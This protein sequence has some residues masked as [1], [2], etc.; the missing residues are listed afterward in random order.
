M[1]TLEHQ[2]QYYGPNASGALANR[3]SKQLPNA[4]IGYNPSGAQ[5][6]N[7][8]GSNQALQPIRQAATIA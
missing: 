2:V 7:S 4:L 8:V 6:S 3:Q 1:A 5:L